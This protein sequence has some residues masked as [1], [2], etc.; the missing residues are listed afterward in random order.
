MPASA[1]ANLKEAFGN[2]LRDARKK[3]NLTQRG[4]AEE[5]GWSG[6]SQ[7]R[8]SNYENG[9]RWPLMDDIIKMAGQV[10]VSAQFLIFGKAGKGAPIAQPELSIED[11]KMLRQF[12]VLDAETQASIK[13]LIA[14]SYA[15][16]RQLERATQRDKAP[17][18]R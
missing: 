10:G 6:E 15:V 11:R 3:A 5:C 14:N 1:S 8:V 17:E 12:K 13:D 4:L 9:E 7:N 18:T 16:A 2:R